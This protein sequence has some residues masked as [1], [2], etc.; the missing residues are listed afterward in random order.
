VTNGDAYQTDDDDDGSDDGG[1]REQMRL[2]RLL[3]L[4]LDRGGENR[5]ENTGGGAGG[6]GGGGCSIYIP[7]VALDSRAAVKKP[8]LGKLATLASLTNTLERKCKRKFED[9]R[10]ELEKRMKC[11]W[12]EEADRYDVERAI[13]RKIAITARVLE[14]MDKSV[15]DGPDA[16][17]TSSASLSPP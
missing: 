17:T 15:Q 10:M 16:A 12:Y 6:G 2:R 9:Q 5:L 13:S 7:E 1:E 11:I 3:G 8:S 4:Q 14:R